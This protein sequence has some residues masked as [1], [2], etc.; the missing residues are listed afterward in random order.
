[1]S[2]TRQLTLTAISA[3]LLCVLAPLS[4]PIGPVPLSLATLVVMLIPYVLGTGKSLLAVALY[5]GL[6]AAGLPVF[7]GFSGGLAKLAGPTGG[8]LIGYL[9]LAFAAGFTLR[10][11][12]GRFWLTAAGL[13]A[14]NLLLYVAGTAWLMVSAGLALPAALA[15]GML[16][17]LP[18]DAVKIIV[19]AKFGPLLAKVKGTPSCTKGSR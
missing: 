18:G 12:K 1:M 5:L 15:A 11:T 10:W 7:S 8:Y 6:G 16:P 14:G 2:R 9:L 17:F 3:A 13:V 4:I 19:A